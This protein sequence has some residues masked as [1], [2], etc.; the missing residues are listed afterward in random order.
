MLYSK[1]ELA[2]TVQGLQTLLYTIRPFKE[3]AICSRT[4]YLHHMRMIL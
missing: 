2:N 4:V 1:E 3:Y